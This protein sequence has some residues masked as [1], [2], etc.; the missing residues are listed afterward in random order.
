MQGGDLTFLK[1]GRQRGVCGMRA[2]D[3][4]FFFQDEQ[5]PGFV[6]REPAI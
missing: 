5:Q 4:T 3:Q 6:Q 2:G 1:R